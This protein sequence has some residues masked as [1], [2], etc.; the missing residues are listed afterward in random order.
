MPE[1]K[2]AWM[3]IEGDDGAS[4]HVEMFQDSTQPRLWLA[5]CIVTSGHWYQYGAKVSS[6]RGFRTDKILED[7]RRTVKNNSVHRDIFTSIEKK[8]VEVIDG[9]KFFIEHTIGIIGTTGDFQILLGEYFQLDHSYLQL[10]VQHELGR[11]A[12]ECAAKV[13]LNPCAAAFVIYYLSCIYDKAESVPFSNIQKCNAERL[14]VTLKYWPLQQAFGNHF[15]SR[16]TETMFYLVR[17]CSS[18]SIWD[19]FVL[20]C[21]PSLSS[22]EI[23]RLFEPSGYRPTVELVEK[24]CSCVGHCE[25]AEKILSAIISRETSLS[26]LCRVIKTFSQSNVQEHRKCLDECRPYFVNRVKEQLDK[27]YMMQHLKELSE[28]AALIVSVDHTSVS[29]VLPTFEQKLLKILDRKEDVSHYVQ[30]LEKVISYPVVFRDK[31]QAVKLLQIFAGSSQRS[32]HELLPRFLQ[33][34]KF[35]VLS[36][37]ESLLQ[38]ID[39]WLSGVASVMPVP[40]VLLTRAREPKSFRD[41][42]AYI[43]E[44]SK[45]PDEVLKTVDV[46]KEIQTRCTKTFYDLMLPSIKQKPNI[47]HL[48]VLEEL[49]REMKAADSQL[50]EDVKPDIEDA[51]TTIVQ[52]E[53]TCDTKQAQILVNLLLLDELFTEA[54]CSKEVLEYMAVSRAQNIHQMFL[55]TMTAEKFWKIVSTGDCEMIFDQWLA[56]AV[57][58]CVD[59]AKKRGSGR[60]DYYILFLYEYL[61]DVL[62]VPSLESNET[63]R[64]QVEITVKKELSEF[65][66][67]KVIDMLK[68]AAGEMKED[69][70]KLLELHLQGAEIKNL[71]S[72]REYHAALD[73]Y[74]LSEGKDLKAKQR[75]LCST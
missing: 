36:D 15:C 51:I 7:T 47:M 71:M 69:A 42:H 32:H 26:A 53:S 63:I 59:K 24:L 48:E 5:C 31:Q 43:F 72:E 44:V 54:N 9:Y 46:K 62:A 41:L 38:L 60:A 64:N 67:K 70:I 56:Q 20:W 58:H 11:F 14:L 27:L 50:F 65:E 29:E 13:V 49:F 18:T 66:P 33:F 8:I 19:S 73:Q 40:A 2:S 16:I 39:Q 37:D 4:R 6:W 23:L 34:Q 57:N 55:K 3:I 45:L 25:G 68:C 17:I 35:S 28:I 21:Y 75:Y 12:T 22:S 74:A 52:K 30:Y 61:A 10:A 1:A